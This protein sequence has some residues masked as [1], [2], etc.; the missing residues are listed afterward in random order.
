MV[1]PFELDYLRRGR[2]WAGYVDIPK[3]SPGSFVLE[4]GCGNGNT[5]SSLR[6][7]GYRT[8]GLD[9]AHEA[10][11]ITGGSFVLMGSIEDLPFDDDVFDAV[12]CRHVLGHVSEKG[13]KK[14]IQELIRVVKPG[15]LVYVVGFS[16][17]DFRYGKGIECEHCSY[18]KGD[19]IMTHYF[20][21]DELRSYFSEYNGSCSVQEKTWT[22]RIR[23][24]YYL[25]SELRC[26]FICDE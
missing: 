26:V 16:V 24:E 7:M 15:G 4:T 22:L 5:L 11:C 14:A 21:N 12:L 6:F 20:E 2:R 9:I 8:V 25:R 17:R 10:V 23:G 13:R 1:S 19:G 3:I 18:L